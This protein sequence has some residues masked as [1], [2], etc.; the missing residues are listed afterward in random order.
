MKAS[1]WTSCRSPL[2]CCINISLCE[3]E[4]QLQL[5]LAGG[6]DWA[7]CLHSS[8]ASPG[9]ADPSRTLEAWVLA[10]LGPRWD[11]AH[12]HPPPPPWRRI[13]SPGRG[14]RKRVC[15][16]QPHVFWWEAVAGHFLS[17]YRPPLLQTG[18]SDPT[19]LCASK[20]APCLAAPCRRRWCVLTVPGSGWGCCPPRPHPAL[21]MAL[22]LESPDL[23]VNPERIA[24]VI[25]CLSNG[26]QAPCWVLG[27]K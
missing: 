24:S 2:T 6:R 22:P 15:G 25:Q 17:W 10:D 9:S 1:L 7:L 5:S 19:R 23:G 16:R 18:K 8:L 13:P 20:P 12:R 3:K 27:L 11:S 4:A 14:G 26:C 21:P